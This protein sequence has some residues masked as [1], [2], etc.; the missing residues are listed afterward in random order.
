WDDRD[1]PVAAYLTPTAVEQSPP[2]A[3]QEQAT[4]QVSAAHDLAPALAAS[5]ALR[6]VAGV[7][8]GCGAA[9]SR[10]PSFDLLGVE[11]GQ[12]PSPDD[13]VGVSHGQLQE[14]VFGW[15]PELLN[16]GTGRSVSPLVLDD[17][18]V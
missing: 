18:A 15:S 5:E 1:R 4:C 14:D 3:A 13:H 6:G 12:V 2:P 16:D 7:R 17:V 11:P 8:F 10:S 9:V